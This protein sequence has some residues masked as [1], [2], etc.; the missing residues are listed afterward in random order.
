MNSDAVLG[1]SS[2]LTLLVALGHLAQLDVGPEAA[3]LGDHVEP[4]LGV[5][6]EHPVAVGRGE[7]LE[8]LDDVE[9]VGRQV[10]GDRRRVLAPLEVR[11]ELARLDHDL[12]AVGRD[13]PAD[14]VDLGRVDR[15]LAPLDQRLEARATRGSRRPARR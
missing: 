5:G 3:G 12:L 13:E 9:L 2:G 6:A 11:A 8:G 14:R 7:Q 10:V 4:G 1:L 15:L